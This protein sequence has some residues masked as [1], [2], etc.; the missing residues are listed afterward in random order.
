[1][2][3]KVR[4]GIL[5]ASRIANSFVK[6]LKMIDDAE[7]IAVGSRSLDKAEKFAQ[8][9]GISKAYGSYEE[10]LADPEIDVVYISTPHMFHKECTMMCLKAGKPVLCEKPFV[11][12]AKEA[13]EVIDF[14]RES[15]LFLMEAMWTRFLPVYDKVRE[16]LSQSA[17]GDIKI[18]KADFGFSA[19]YN[20]EGRVFNR[21][22]GGG[23]LLDVG[24]YTL[25]FSSMIF[26]LDVSQISSCAHIGETSVDEEFSSILKYKNGEM[27]LIAGAIRTDMQQDAWICGSNGRIHIPDFWRA[28]SATLYVQG[29][30]P[31]TVTYPFETTGYQFE[32]LE[33]M[34]CLRQGR[35]ESDRMPLDETY[36]L[37]ETL[38]I[39]RAQLGISYPSDN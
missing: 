38:D 24:I 12:N 13:R 2:S 31:I 10:F 17:I 6:S 16:W 29:N 20:P 26:G 35:L 36:K 15:K 5:A 22:L 18:V 27:A 7:I 23:A 11:M 19:Q 25:A 33:V 14:A 39:I 1:M 32:A 30:D 4:W 28:K 8:K 9:Y 21:G 37:S 34:R 3:N